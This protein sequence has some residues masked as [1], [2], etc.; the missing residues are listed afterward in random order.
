[1]INK[2]FVLGVFLGVFIGLILSLCTKKLSIPK[3]VLITHP[4]SWS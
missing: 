4:A 3:D 1:M 2:N